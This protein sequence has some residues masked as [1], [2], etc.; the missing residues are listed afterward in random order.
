MARRKKELSR[1]DKLMDE[2]LSEYRGPEE[3]LGESGLIKQ[4]TKRAIERA[5][6]G[7]L[8]HHL[9]TESE[10]EGG[11]GNSRNGYSKKTVRSE[12]S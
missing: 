12:H 9:D 6:E 8:K 7:E 10:Q 4:L 1:A 11:K 3:I 5:L 2:L